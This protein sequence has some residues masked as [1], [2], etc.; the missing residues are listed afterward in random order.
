MHLTWCILNT[1]SF[2]VFNVIQAMHCLTDLFTYSMI[3]LAALKKLQFDQSR[4]SR[5]WNVFRGKILDEHL[6]LIIHASLYDTNPHSHTGAAF[7]LIRKILPSNFCIVQL[8][9]QIPTKYGYFIGMIYFSTKSSHIQN[10]N[11]GSEAS[12]NKHVLQ[13]DLRSS[14]GLKNCF[15]WRFPACQGVRVGKS[16]WVFS[17]LFLRPTA[18]PS[19]GTESNHG[20]APRILTGMILQVYYGRKGILLKISIHLHQVWSPQNGKSP[21]RIGNTSSNGGVFGR[22]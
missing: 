3:W 12:R 10:P 17:L 21:F 16:W 13:I 11:W 7:F 1:F 2:H 5:E 14:I 19:W 15:W 22:V 20:Y 8:S 4:L 6:E 9:C 18:S